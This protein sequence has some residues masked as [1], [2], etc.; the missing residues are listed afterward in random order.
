[1][2]TATA[3]ASPSTAEL[4][5][6][7]NHP[8]TP[9]LVVQN[10]LDETA[11]FSLY[12][13]PDGGYTQQGTL[14]P[15][16][17]E[18]FFGINGGYGMDF[19]C[20]LHGFDARAPIVRNAVQPRTHAGASVG[21]LRS[22][23]YFTSDP[24][25]WNPGQ[26]PTSSIFDPWRSKPFVMPDL[27][28]DFGSGEWV[29]LHVVG[30]TW[31][32]VVEG[33]VRVLAGAAGDIVE[34]AGRFEGVQGTLTMN[35]SLTPALG[36]AGN[37]ILR[38]IDHGNAIR[39]PGGWPTLEQPDR[40]DDGS[41]WMV[42]RGEKKNP[43]VR[44]LVGEPRGQE[45]QLVTPSIMRPLEFTCAGDDERRIRTAHRQG[46]VAAAMSASV[47]F[48]LSAPRPDRT[49]SVP[50]TT[51][52][53]YNFSDG[54]RAGGTVEAGVES[55]IS[56]KLTFPGRPSQP[57][58]RFAGAGPVTCGTGVFEKAAGLLTV[59][60]LIGISPH[61]LSLIHVLQIVKGRGVE[62]IPRDRIAG[63]GWR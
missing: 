22:R 10:L 29:R 14:T 58:V 61:A 1:M 13:E 2:A 11:D 41:A 9:Y 56:F 55:G 45:Q 12:A 35:G 59:N 4:E 49:S 62:Q 54:P 51:S 20:R 50:F 36:F 30:R 27:R 34:G 37:V 43:G 19:V 39:Q 5:E 7:I 32:V 60:S 42:L 63:K 33:V 17:P 15:G 25:G 57:G 31:P 23:L 48:N 53:V 8:I 46:P 18:D 28:I 3:F 26:I 24:A 38:V 6:E 16:H 40:L 47:F 52:E 21:T 44:T